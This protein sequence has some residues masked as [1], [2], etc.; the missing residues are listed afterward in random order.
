MQRWNGSPLH[1]RCGF[2]GDADGQVD[3]AS[4]SAAPDAVVAVVGAIED[5]VLVD[6]QAVRAL[7]HAFAPGA[8]EIAV[9][10]NTSIGCSPRLNT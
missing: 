2:A 10:S 9:R 7:E 8:Q 6:I 4:S 1:E 3:F 5:V